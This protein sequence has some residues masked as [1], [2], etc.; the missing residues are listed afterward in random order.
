MK[1]KGGGVSTKLRPYMDILSQNQ[2]IEMRRE[3]VIRS[4][5]LYLG[6]KE[7][8]LFEDCQEDNH[9]DTT[10]HTLKILVVYGVDGKDPVDVA[11]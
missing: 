5:I 6:E 10:L 3:A 1:L 9:S 8:E 2:N 4:L 7:E 11:L